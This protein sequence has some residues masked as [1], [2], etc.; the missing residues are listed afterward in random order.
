MA[1][2]DT[3]HRVEEVADILSHDLKNSLNVARGNLELAR[4]TGEEEF[5]ETAAAALDRVEELIEEVVYLAR[6]G[7]FIEELELVDLGER[8]AH[9]WESVRTM[10]AALEIVSSSTFMASNR[11]ISHLL[12]NLIENAIVHAGPEVTVRVGELEG[13]FFVEDD[14][15]GIPEEHRPHVFDRGYTVESG[16][17]GLGLHIVFRIA[18]AHGWGATVTSSIDGGARFEFSGVEME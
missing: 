4:E 11:G 10:D 8:T 5:F 3:E 13:G 12:E 1:R 15:P 18:E 6:T 16:T 7:E 2:S 17:S 14:G 9:A